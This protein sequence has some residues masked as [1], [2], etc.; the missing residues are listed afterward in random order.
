MAATPLRELVADGVGRLRDRIGE[1][2]AAEAGLAEM[3]LA[4]ASVRVS[5][6]APSSEVEKALAAPTRERI[7]AEA[8]EAAFARRAAAVDKE[9]A[10]AENELANRIEIARRTADLVEQEGANQ[11]RTATEAAAAA[12]IAAESKAAATTGTALHALTEL[13]DRGQELPVLPDSAKADLAAYAEA[14]KDLKATHIETFCV[15]DALKIGGTPDRVVSYKGKR[16]IADVKTGSIEWGTYKIAMQLAVY[17][18]SKTYDIAT[19]ERGTHNAELDKGIIIHLPAGTG[20]CELVW[21]DLVE[22]WNGVTLARQVRAKRALKF[23]D[24]TTP[25]ASASAPTVL[26]PSAA[27]S[28]EDQIKACATAD[29]VRALWAEH[30]SEWDDHLTEVARLHIASLP[31]AS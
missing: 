11:R 20:T 5:A 7:S 10:I 19:G 23:G 27:P 21:V 29:A 22:G 18:R 14:T 16:Y 8:D 1:G 4:I 31:T 17:A 28:L 9:R 25:F 26:E 30:A 3:G 2:L 13:V 15:L 6:V 12:Q 24:L